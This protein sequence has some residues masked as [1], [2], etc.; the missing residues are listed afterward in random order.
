MC[1]WALLHWLTA[2]GP[3]PALYAACR[4][5][6]VRMLCNPQLY[7]VPLDAVDSDPLMQVP[8]C[9]VAAAN[10]GLCAVLLR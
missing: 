4:Y 5:M 9:G 8:G 7:G 6:Y 1:C 2:L 3:L 10:I